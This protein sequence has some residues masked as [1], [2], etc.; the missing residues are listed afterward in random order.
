MVP[1]LFGDL[2]ALGTEAANGGVLF[3]HSSVFWGVVLCKALW[4]LH[5]QLIGQVMEDACTVLHR[6]H[7]GEETTGQDSTGDS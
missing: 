5:L 4:G 6:L 3:H 7:R 1:H 2:A